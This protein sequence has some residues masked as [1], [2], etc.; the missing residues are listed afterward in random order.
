M[1]LRRL[2]ILLWF[3]LLVSIP[4]F[5][6]LYQ[7]RFTEKTVEPQSPVEARETNSAVNIGGAYSLVNSSN[8]KVTDKTFLGKPTLMFFGFT[9]CPAIC[10]GTLADI[11]LWYEKL[12]KQ[13]ADK[14]Q[15]LFITVDP[16]RDTPI[17]LREY[18]KA[19]DPHIVAL[20]GTP[21]QIAAM[22]SLYRVYYKKMPPM[23]DGGYM[24][25]HSASIY[26]FD[27]NGKLVSTIDPDESRDVA[28]AKVKKLI[29][30]Y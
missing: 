21:E 26:A 24:V 8:E 2:R 27:A 20:T 6:Q 15:T 30:A 4:F 11:S 5:A 12:G 13:D 29:A 16:E 19:F 1:N 28:F 3:L 23:K 25:N 7:A 10:P 22:T 14:L 9:H 18:M 17:V